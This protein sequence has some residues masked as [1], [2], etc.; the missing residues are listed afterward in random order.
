MKAVK[1]VMTWIAR[2]GL[3]ALVAVLAV[4]LIGAILG[5]YLFGW[6]W[7]GVGSKTLWEWMQLLVIPAVLAVGGYLFNSQQNRLQ[8]EATEQEKDN[9]LA[10]EADKQQQAALEAY[11]DHM[12]DLLLTHQLGKSDTHPEAPKLA[13]VRTLTVVRQLNGERTGFVLHFLSEY[14]LIGGEAPAISLAEADLRDAALTGADL[15]GAD[16]SGALLNAATLTAVNL[17]KAN[18]SGANL[19]RYPFQ[20]TQSPSP[21]SL[22][23]VDLS[24]ADLS[25]AILEEVVLNAVRLDE[26][27]LNGAHLSQATLSGVTLVGADLTDAD[28]S[29]A[30]MSE[31]KLDDETKRFINTNDGW[32]PMRGTLSGGVNLAGANLTRAHLGDA[33]LGPAALT[34]AVFA[35]A[36]LCGADLSQ[37]TGHAK[38]YAGAQYN[39]ATRW[40]PGVRPETV[41]AVRRQG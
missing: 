16:L 39:K 33:K 13:R 5:G 15:S 41:G 36:N 28:L 11:V 14:G 40:P 2:P 38:S 10:V 18:L 25:G 29:G 3:V 35:E 34:D 26:A 6:S 4:G 1:S 37:T 9:D 30:T 12:S 24:G 21:A 8:R 27:H 19:S 7:A 32:R 17:Q 23:L 20:D 22:L 31:V